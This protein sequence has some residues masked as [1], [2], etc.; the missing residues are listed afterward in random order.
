M[1]EERELCCD[2]LLDF[3]NIRRPLRVGPRRLRVAD[4]QLMSYHVNLLALG[5]KFPRFISGRQAHQGG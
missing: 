1:L 4:K 2:S 5:G 3:S